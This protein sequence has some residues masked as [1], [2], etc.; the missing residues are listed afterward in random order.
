MLVRLGMRSWNE[1]FEHVQGGRFPPTLDMGSQH[2]CA[3]WIAFEAGIQK[4]M[5]EYT[6]GDARYSRGPTCGFMPG[7]LSVRLSAANSPNGCHEP[8]R[9]H[10]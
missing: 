2:R 10:N 4:S 5:A 6:S 8:F 1:T 9:R 7:G 3:Y